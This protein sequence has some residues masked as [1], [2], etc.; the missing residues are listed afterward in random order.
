MAVTF[1]A[2]VDGDSVRTFNAVAPA[3][4]QSLPLEVGTSK[5]ATTDS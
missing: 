4:E 2:G 5:T 3:P 1:G